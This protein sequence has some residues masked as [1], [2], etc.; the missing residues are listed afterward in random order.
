MIEKIEEKINAHIK[1]I[2]K[3][4]AI[5]FVDYQILSSHLAKLKSDEQQKKWDEE[6]DERNEKF[7]LLMN[8][9]AK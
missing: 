8:A 7:R 6:N 1:S 4:D 5:D 9:F 2:L 3:K